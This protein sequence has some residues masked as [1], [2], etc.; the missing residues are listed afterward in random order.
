[1][2]QLRGDGSCV[3]WGFPRSRMGEEDLNAIVYLEGDPE[4]HGMG[5]V[6]QRGEGCQ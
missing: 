6:R 5:V 2:I 1:M 3:D 4:Q